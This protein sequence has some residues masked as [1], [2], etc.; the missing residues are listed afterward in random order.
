MT[1]GKIFI[2]AGA[3]RN[4]KT[5]YTIEQV[6]NRRRVIV[7]DVEGEFKKLRGFVAVSSIPAL[8][9]T[10]KKAGVKPCR[11]AY[12]PNNTR[13]FS[14][15]SKIALAWG[16]AVGDVAAVA[17]ETSDVTTPGKA[18]DGWGQLIRKG[19]K[20]GIDIFAISQR[21]AESDKTALGNAKY[22]ISFYL[23]RPR[24]R[25]Y[26]AA[27]MGCNPEQIE[28]LEKLHYLKKDVDNR[29]LIK[30]QIQFE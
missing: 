26:I 7:W 1:E 27:E 22:I 10:V 2:I 6:K 24:D 12:Q 20:R 29:K 5:V 4:G 23:N 9:E 16:R 19:M 3:S 17:E 11:I 25:E 21:P 30:G 14:D 13:E 8:L 15:W 18:P 28:Q